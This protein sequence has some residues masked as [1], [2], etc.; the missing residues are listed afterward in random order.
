VRKESAPATARSGCKPAIEE[1][2]DTV[3]MLVGV[4]PLTA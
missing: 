4:L 3:L 2:A 1:F